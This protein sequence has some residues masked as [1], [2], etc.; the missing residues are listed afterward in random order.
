[1]TETSILAL[2]LDQPWASLVAT[3]RPDDPSIGL[4]EYETR[5]WSTPYR[6]DILLHATQTI[7]E[8]IA[9]RLADELHAAGTLPAILPRGCF[10]AVARILEIYPTEKA[11][12]WISEREYSFGD[13]R[14]G[15]FAWRLGKLRPLAAPLE[16]R[17]YQKFF[18]KI[19]PEVLEAVRAVRGA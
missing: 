8:G 9:R 19:P 7:P 16:G 18:S 2:S 17:G 12:E 10:L 1:M 4:K 3:P 15:R 13:Y 6:G 14:P 5:S 11:V